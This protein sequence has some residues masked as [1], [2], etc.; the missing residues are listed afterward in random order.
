MEAYVDVDGESV[1]NTHTKYN[2]SSLSDS[3]T[4]FN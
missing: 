2:D 3:V 1:V 4:F